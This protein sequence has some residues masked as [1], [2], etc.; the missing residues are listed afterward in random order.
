MT[1][2]DCV[3]AMGQMPFHRY[4]SATYVCNLEGGFSCF[5]P[6]LIFLCLFAFC[7]TEWIA[8][9][10]S[11]PIQA[12]PIWETSPEPSFYSFRSI[13]LF[14]LLF[15][16]ILLFQ[17]LP[18]N[19]HCALPICCMPLLILTS[20]LLNAN[21]KHFQNVCLLVDSTSEILQVG[22]HTGSNS[23]PYQDTA[24]SGIEEFEV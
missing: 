18:Y 5:L 12:V 14:C 4:N 21:F 15:V 2:I 24:K 3:S 9:P 6:S 20:S 19:C 22:Q 13:C 17:C 1:Y 8:R 16:A 11:T 7:G 10:Q 23:K